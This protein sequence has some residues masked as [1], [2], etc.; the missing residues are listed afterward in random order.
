MHT[1]SCQNR[2]EEGEYYDVQIPVQIN[3][4]LAAHTAVTGLSRA[5]AIDVCNRLNGGN[6]FPIGGLAE[7]TGKFS[8]MVSLF[9]Q[10]LK[11]YE[12]G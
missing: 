9:T 11:E 4:Q 1:I 12:N 2:G 7:L 8:E 10:R 3:G 5:E 6:S